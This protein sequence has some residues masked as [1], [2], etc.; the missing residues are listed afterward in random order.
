MATTFCVLGSR[1][2]EMYG[3]RCWSSAVNADDGSCI[4]A[5][6]DNLDKEKVVLK[7]VIDRRETTDTERVFMYHS[8]TQESAGGEEKAAAWPPRVII[9]SHR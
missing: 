3:W 4:Y 5:K 1:T 2:D 9:I 6:C 8:I 7:S